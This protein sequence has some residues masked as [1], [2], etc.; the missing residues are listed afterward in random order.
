VAHV[1]TDLVRAKLSELQAKANAR[2]ASVPWQRARYQSID[3]DI[4]RL[5][6]RLRKWARTL[7]CRRRL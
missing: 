6:Q 1:V 2:S 4:E 3:P 5:N 7:S